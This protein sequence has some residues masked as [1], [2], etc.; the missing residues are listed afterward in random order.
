MVVI[1]VSKSP[2]EYMLCANGG[3]VI[4]YQNPSKYLLDSSIF[5]MSHINILLNN[6]GP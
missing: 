5:L 3:F 1:N 2:Y 4:V 6:N